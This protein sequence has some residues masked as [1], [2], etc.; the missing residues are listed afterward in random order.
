MHGSSRL[1]LSS[2]R[3]NEALMSVIDANYAISRRTRLPVV[4]RICARAA[5]AIHAVRRYTKQRPLR[6]LDVGAA[7]GQGLAQMAAALGP[8]NLI[9]VERSEIL[10][11]AARDLPPCTELTDGDAMCL[12]DGMEERS[13]DV[14]TMLAVL[15]H[16]SDPR[17]AVLEAV[18]LLRHGGL[19]VATC[20]NPAWDVLSEQTG[21][22]AD[23]HHLNAI[24]LPHLRGLL[25]EA[26]CRILEARRFMW[27]PVAVL[28]Y[29]RIPVPVPLAR[30]LDAVVNRIPLL[31]RLCVNAC[32][33]ARR[34]IAPSR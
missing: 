34:G 7:D 29:A 11:A 2:P 22:E 28:P 4:Y 8:G 20:P 27:A 16:L 32:V 5:L 3:G 10:R 19:L 31:R 17:G 14:L 12:T 26:G 21:L 13:F 23:H 33:V 15:E 9:G 18:R 25:E 24:G 30:N 1:D 6:V